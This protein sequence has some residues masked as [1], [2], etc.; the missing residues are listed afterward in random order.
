MFEFADIF[1]PKRRFLIAGIAAIIAIL[2]ISLPAQ[3]LQA[4]HAAIAAQA[5]AS[6]DDQ[7]TQNAGGSPNAVTNMLSQM[8]NDAGPVMKTAGLR[9]LSGVVG[10]LAVVA[11]IDKD[12][13]Q[14]ARIA[15]ISTLHGIGVGAIDTAHVIGSGFTFAGNTAASAIWSFHGV[16]H[17]SAIIQPKDDSPTPIITE[18][19]IQQA[20][21][22]QSV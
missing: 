8:T 21:L 10:G 6:Y 3:L 13:V 9:A 12:I 14:G 15:T 18:L 4:R 5:Q 16:T 19:R 22:I 11:H 17:L 7:G 1:F 2:L 20:A